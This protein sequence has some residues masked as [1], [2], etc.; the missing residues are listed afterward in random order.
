MGLG[1]LWAYSLR[2]K[3][4]AIVGLGGETNKDEK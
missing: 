2:P 1:S 4:I 3:N